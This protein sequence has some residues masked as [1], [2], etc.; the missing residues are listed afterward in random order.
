MKKSIFHIL[1]LMLMA[2][3]SG[4]V[5]PPPD[6]AGRSVIS[7]SE[8]VKVYADDS[9]HYGY[10]ISGISSSDVCA[11]AWARHNF[12]FIKNTG[13]YP[14][15]CNYFS[16]ELYGLTYDGKILDIK[17]KDILRYPDSPINPGRTALFR[18]EHTLSQFMAIFVHLID[19]TDIKLMRVPK[20]AYEARKKYA[21]EH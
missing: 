3:I 19:G 8:E 11:R 4:C 2:I 6:F 17:G 18:S 5:S 14:L 15:Q 13:N 21:E 12:I 10:T 7:F 20:D 1:Y 16:D 9:N